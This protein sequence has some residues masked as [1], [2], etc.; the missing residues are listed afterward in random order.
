MV[1]ISKNLF[2]LF[3]LFPLKQSPTLEKG[4]ARMDMV[5]EGRARERLNNSGNSGNK[6]LKPY[7]HGH[8]MPFPLSKIVGTRV[9]T[10]GTC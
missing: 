4:Y 3:P 9:G 10:V 7:N 2:P 1:G 5:C 8:L 6:L